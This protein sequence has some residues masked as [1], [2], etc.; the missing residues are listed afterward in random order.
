MIAGHCCLCL[1]GIHLASL[2]ALSLVGSK[3]ALLADI[4]HDHLRCPCLGEV[5]VGA[6][7]PWAEV[8]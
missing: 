3:E 5:N 1:A 4:N 2:V 8:K 6:Q 7:N